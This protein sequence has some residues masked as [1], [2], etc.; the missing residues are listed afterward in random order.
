MVLR[1]RQRTR[2]PF[3][4]VLASWMMWTLLCLTALANS[5]LANSAPDVLALT[6]EK[7]K[8]QPYRILSSFC[9]PQDQAASLSDVALSLNDWPWQTS[10]RGELPNFGFTTDV[11]WV[12]FDLV[13]ESKLTDWLLLLSYPMLGDVELLAFRPDAPARPLV[14][15][16]TGA[17]YLFSERPYEYSEFVFPLHLEPNQRTTVLL[18]ASG[19]YS[20]QIPL[21]IISRERLSQTQQLTVLVHGFFFG[22]MLVMMFYNLFLYYSIREKAY[23]LYVFWTFAIT[24]FQAILH[25][26]AQQYFWPNTAFLSQYAMTLLLPFIVILPPLFTIHFLSLDSRAPRYGKLLRWHV[27]V[28]V[29]LLAL[30]PFIDRHYLAPAEALAIILMVV[31]VFYIAVVRMRAG[32]P[33]A[34][35]FTIAWSCFLA[36]AAIMVVNKY[37]LLPRNEFTENL[38]QTGTFLEVILLSLALADRINRLKE[39]HAASLQDRA[40]AEMDAFKA[41]AHNQAKSE[42]LATMSHEI[43]TPMNG[44]LGMSDLLRRTR[45]DHQQSQYVDTIYE[46]TQS[47]LTVINDILDYS[48]IEAGKLELEKIDVSVEQVIDDCVS[49]FALQSMQK[50]L[51]LYTFIDSRVSGIIRTDPVRLKQIITN[52]LSNAFKFTES[53][54]ITLSVSLRGANAEQGQCELMFEVADT[55]IGL[56]AQQQ[57]N[58]FRAFSQ[59]DSSPTRR[60]GGSG[61]GLTISKRLCAMLDGDIG[62]DSSPGR[63]ATFWF[64]VRADSVRPYQPAQALKGRRLLVINDDSS[65]ALSISQMATRWGMV[66]QTV[67]DLLSAVQLLETN[68]A[69]G[70]HTDVV[71]IDH[72]LVPALSQLE[73][74]LEGETLPVMMISHIGGASPGHIN[75]GEYTLVEIPVRAEALKDALVNLL[76]ETDSDADALLVTEAQLDIPADVRVLV[77]E[78]NP[79]NQL[80]IDS[81]L[82]SAGIKAR[83]AHNGAEALH[84]TNKSTLPWDL[85][86]MDCEMPVMD[87]LEATRRLREMEAERGQANSWVIG[88]SAHALADHVQRAHNSGMDDYL[89]KPVTREDVLTALSGAVLRT[90]DGTRHKDTRSTAPVIPLRS[91]R[92][93]S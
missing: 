93:D 4:Q 52:L 42:F 51:P 49:L 5:A 54:H 73:P 57:Q 50:R 12:R 87:G 83:L 61:L 65:F 63:G 85:V 6:D 27:K 80:V 30:L 78:D 17:D 75:L 89:T 32:D 35:Y 59:L 79:V 45:L 47:L 62:V 68:R 31:N 2:S 91:P 38:V 7:Q 53:G 64:T 19:A 18:R 48:R 56:D 29:T 76:C 33:D 92:R 39:A 88:L 28:G 46:S 81:I 23:L 84:E 34:R 44:V 40:Q 71:L 55:G 70:V 74:V 72:Q 60:A 9:Q 41:S 10:R 21:N 14:Q 13:R 1:R 58:L 36:G 43:R 24:L 20:V 37:A 67:R 69:G 8:V 16:Q 77:V 26:F 15:Y 25:G 22:G 90:R 11:C 66:A 86:F 82:K 3:M